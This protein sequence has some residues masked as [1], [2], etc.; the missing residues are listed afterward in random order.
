MCIRVTREYFI[1]TNLSKP[2]K[3]E[4]EDSGPDEGRISFWE[5]QH[6]IPYFMLLATF[7]FAIV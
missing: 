2:S 6:C 7:F 1:M 4:F 3:P 5:Q